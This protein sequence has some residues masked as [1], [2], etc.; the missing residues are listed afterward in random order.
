MKKILFILSALLL[1]GGGLSAQSTP[2]QKESKEKFK[3]KK[4]EWNLGENPFLVKDNASK[5]YYYSYADDDRLTVTPAGDMTFALTGCDASKTRPLV[6]K[7]NSDETINGILYFSGGYYYGLEPDVEL[8]DPVFGENSSDFNNMFL[9]SYFELDGYAY[10]VNAY[11]YSVV[12]TNLATGEQITATGTSGYASLAYDGQTFWASGGND[13]YI[14]ALDADLNPTGKKINVGYSSFV[15]WTGTELLACERYNPPYKSDVSGSR[16]KTYDVDGNLT[17]DYGVTSVPVYM[18]AT[19][20]P[21]TGI[22][23]ASTRGS[24]IGF[25]LQNGKVT[26]EAGSYYYGIIAG[27]DNDGLPYITDYDNYT[28]YKAEK[29]SIMPKGLN[30]SQSAINLGPGQQVTVNITVDAQVGSREIGLYCYGMGDMLFARKMVIE[31][32]AEPEFEAT[33]GLQ[34]S[35]FADYPAATQTAWIKNTGCSPIIFDEMPTIG[36]EY[37]EISRLVPSDFEGYLSAGDSVGAVISFFT[38]TAGEYKDTMTIVTENAGTI[39]IP[40][41]ATASE[42][43]YTVPESVTAAIDCDANT[44]SA[45]ATIANNSNATMTIYGKANV[46]FDIYTVYCTSEISIRLLDAKGNVLYYV[47]ENTYSAQNMHYQVEQNLP[48]GKY[49]LQ[50]GDRCADTWDGGGYMN[51]SAE[52]Q[53]ILNHIQPVQGKYVTEFTFE[54]NPSLNVKVAAGQTIN[55]LSFPIAGLALDEPVE[56]LVSFDGLSE[57]ID[58]ITVNLTSGEPELTVADTFDLGQ[59][60]FSNSE[61]FYYY[62]YYFLQPHTF[63]IANTGC[64]PLYIDKIEVNNPR[65][66]LY[67]ENAQ[68]S[69]ASFVGSLEDIEIDARGTYELKLY[70]YPDSAGLFTDNLS[71]IVGDDTTNVVLT[72][73][74]VKMPRL[75]YEGEGLGFV[76]DTVDCNATS[77]TIKGRIANSGEGDLIV[78]EPIKIQYQAGNVNAG[79]FG[80]TNTELGLSSNYNY[81]YFEDGDFAYFMPATEGEYTVEVWNNGPNDGKLVITSGDKTVLALDLATTY[82]NNTRTFT[83]T[84][85]DIVRDTV[86][87]GDTIDIEM[88]VEFTSSASSLPGPLL[89][90]PIG[91]NSRTF[92][93]QLASNDPYADYYYP[94]ITMQGKVVIVEAAPQLV[95]P[96]TV[97]F[98]EVSVGFEERKDYE[99]ENNSCGGYEIDNIWVVNNDSPLYADEDGIWFEP[100]TEGTFYNTLK[101]A[102]SYDSVGT[103]VKDTFDIVLSGVCVASPIAEYN[104]DPIEIV[105]EKGATSVKVTSAAISNVGTATALKLTEAKLAVLHVFTGTGSTPSKIGWQLDRLVNG[106]PAH[107]KSVNCNTYTESNQMFNY[108]LGVLS[109]GDYRLDMFDQ[110]YGSW[111]NGYIWITTYDGTAVLLDQT[112][113][114]NRSYNSYSYFVAEQESTTVSVAAGDSVKFEWEIPVKGLDAGDYYFGRVYRTNDANM[115]D[116]YINVKV[117]INEDYAYDYNKD[118]IMFT[119]VH[120]KT[121]AY[122]SVTLRNRGTIAINMT[123]NWFKSEEDDDAEQLF[124][125]YRVSGSANVEDSLT[126]SIK[127]KGSEVAGI[128]RDT[129]YVEHDYNDSVFLDTIPLVATVNNTQVIAVST[130]NSRYAVAGDTIDIN[131]S[132][133]S[134]VIIVTDTTFKESL[135]KLAMNT[136]GFAL[137]DTTTVT[138]FRE[139]EYTITFRYAVLQADNVDLFDYTEDSIYMMGC[140]LI[141][142]DGMKFDEV[143]LPAVGTL[144]S[145]FPVT[146]DNILPVYVAAVSDTV[147]TDS[148]VTLTVLFSEAVKGFGEDVIALSNGAKINNFFASDATTYVAELVLPHAAVTNIS[149]NAEVADLAGNAIKIAWS[150]NVATVHDFD[151]TVVE[152]TFDNVGYKKLVCKICGETIYIDTVP[153]VKLESIALTSLPAKLNYNLGEVIDLTG[154]QLTLTFNNGTTRVIDLTMAMISGFDVTASGKQTITV[155]YV[156]NGETFTTT[157]DIEIAN[158]SAVSEIAA[159]EVSIYAFENTIVVEAEADGSEIAVFDVNGRMVAKATATSSRTEIEMSEAGVYVVRIGNTAQSVAIK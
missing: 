89:P 106:N 27:F 62:Y 118:S 7:N 74:G 158:I 28:L 108:E 72:A 6:V 53:I 34:F 99:I 37:F 4:F 59:Q 78:N 146:I 104:D 19:Y 21:G 25:S 58:T 148:V 142:R 23:W 140:Q 76:N 149:I 22:V 77:A 151:T 138:P 129:L 40:F 116:I 42:L 75:E 130:P 147:T 93:Y 50:L 113:K 54:V 117:T 126:I 101:L 110:N 145:N 68:Y 79:A 128:F 48:K 16:M 139:D 8:G 9:F 56:L 32:D 136:N 144:S 98:G 109:A 60:L 153:A 66:A 111:N 115:P 31:V 36:T 121:P 57:A 120:T 64:G 155:T 44:A 26:L 20:E 52:G 43:G 80:V 84:A 124:E 122:S 119:P 39:K 12:R 24:L 95:L 94:Y 143:K 18:N 47:P 29:F 88:T 10:A 123:D 152:P 73:T 14:Y 85:N 156:E 154:A 45:N 102:I 46:L 97:N 132:F 127:F 15:T 157:F 49:T 63:T 11:M 51:V 107:I 83:L 69:F 61:E 125:I 91:D 137:L 133:D 30:L 5:D 17:A 38:E 2:A 90:Y 141:D 1:T 87:P 134:P 33:N 100:T 86:A 70:I 96:D 3:Q 35:A 41:A 150:S 131:V 82:S 92:T 112:K 67:D 13:N 114:Q 159:A 71:V 81:T 105:A 55:K 103:E 65:F 135:P